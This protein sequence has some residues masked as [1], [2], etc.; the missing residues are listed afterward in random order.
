MQ[1]ML[2]FCILWTFFQDAKVMETIAHASSLL[3]THPPSCLPFFF[4]QCIWIQD[5][6]ACTAFPHSLHCVLIHW[7]EFQVKL[8]VPLNTVITWHTLLKL[9]PDFRSLPFVFVFMPNALWVC[10]LSIWIINNTSLN[11][12]QREL[13][14]QCGGEKRNV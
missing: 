10:F 14:F 11:F 1:R 7:F 5:L 3:P 2:R 12:N 13:V 9:G 6:F 4:W 8:D